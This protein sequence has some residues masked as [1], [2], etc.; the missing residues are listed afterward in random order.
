MG[1]LAAA[2]IVVREVPALADIA[3][4]NDLHR[5][6]VFA[7]FAQE[8]SEIYARHAALYRPRTVEIIEI[9]KSLS[10]DELAALRGNIAALRA[11]LAGLMDA[12]GI[13]LWI[14]PAARGPAPEGLHATG[15]P[16]MNLP[17]THAG[18]P[19]IT[20]PAGQAENGLPMGLQLV[21]R[22]GED[23]ALLGWALEHVT[24]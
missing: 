21:G 6:L 15:D 7:E 22:F 1:Q 19:S 24:W 4:L 13:D 14:C 23:E 17:W 12:A 11:E 16:N 10:T 20:L 9:G 5:R 18:L 2:G 8:H 3:A